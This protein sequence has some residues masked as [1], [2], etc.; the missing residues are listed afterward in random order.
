MKPFD[1]VNSISSNKN[2]KMD[3]KLDESIYNPFITNRALSYFIDTI[4]VA[5][6]M[7]INHHLENKLQYEYLLNKVR[8][9]KRF[10][11][12]HKNLDDNNIE[13]IKQYYKVN[14]NKAKIILSIL[15]EKQLDSIRHKLDKG[16]LK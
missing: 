10:S 9:R 7:N 3:S 4:L 13:I 6:E 15:N 1:Y 16:G 8:K 5:N 2:I 14:N 12:W 11:K